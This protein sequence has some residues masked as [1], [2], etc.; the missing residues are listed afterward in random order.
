M[1]QYTNSDA[2]QSKGGL[3][4]KFCRRII[5]QYKITIIKIFRLTDLNFKNMM[6]YIFYK[7]DQFELEKNTSNFIVFHN[8]LTYSCSTDHWS[9]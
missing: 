3:D 2:D 9:Y 7:I 8:F 6:T 4:F 5:E 1:S